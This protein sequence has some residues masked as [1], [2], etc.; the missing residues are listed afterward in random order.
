MEFLRQDGEDLLCWHEVYGAKK[1]WHL[2]EE[3]ERVLRSGRRALG[4]RQ[5]G[6]YA[7]RPWGPRGRAVLYFV[8]AMES[9]EIHMKARGDERSISSFARLQSAPDLRS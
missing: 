8:R 1:P 7:V 3:E 9:N 5:V 2:L 6:A 4:E